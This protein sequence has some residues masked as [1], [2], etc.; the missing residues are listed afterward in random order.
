MQ[1]EGEGGRQDLLG[2]RGGNRQPPLPFKVLSQWLLQAGNNT[3]SPQEHVCGRDKLA[4]AQLCY[5]TMVLPLQAYLIYRL[6]E[7]FKGPEKSRLYCLRHMYT[8]CR[9][10][11]IVFEPRKQH[12][13]D[14]CGGV[15]VRTISVMSASSG[16]T[17]AQTGLNLP[18]DPSKSRTPTIL[19]M[20]NV[21]NCWYTSLTM[22]CSDL[23]MRRAYERR[24]WSLKDTISRHLT[25]ACAPR[26]TVFHFKM[27]K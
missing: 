27:E 22:S 6:E 25:M 11:D 10:G 20:P 9:H 18:R 2:I 19:G 3:F 26:S 21:W 14:R 23:L 17:L 12:T 1:Q 24:M 13:G 16:R 15:V 4:L 8:Y 7:A 5:F